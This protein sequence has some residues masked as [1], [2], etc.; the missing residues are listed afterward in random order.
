MGVFFS[1][2]RHRSPAYALIRAT[3]PYLDAYADY[4]AAGV[5]RDCAAAGFGRI[6]CAA[7][8]GRHFALVATRGGSP[9]VDDRRAATALPDTHLRTWESGAAS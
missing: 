9:V 8:T 1:S 7:A 3:E 4:G 2:D 6:R 5:A